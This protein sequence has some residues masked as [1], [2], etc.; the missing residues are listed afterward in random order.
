[1][2]N[3]TYINN[4]TRNIS[5]TKASILQK[6]NDDEAA[7]LLPVIVYVFILMSVGIVGNLIVLYIYKFRFRRS[8]SRAF[9]LCLAILDLITCLFGMPF[10][11]ID[12]NFPFLFVWDVPCKV[13]YFLLSSTIHASTFI[14]VLI[15]IERYRKI[16]LPFEKQISDIGTKAICTGCI[17]VAFVLST[18]VLFL[19]G[20]T[21]FDTG[22]SNITGYECYISNDYS[23]SIFPLIYDIVTIILFVGSTC[24]LTV[25][26]TRIG[27]KVWRKGTFQG[28]KTKCKNGRQAS[29]H[30]KQS[31]ME[32]VIE[33]SFSNKKE[34]PSQLPVNNKN[35]FDEYSNILI[36]SP[37]L[38]KD[39]GK[40][41][42]TRMDIRRSS[43]RL[44]W[45]ESK[46][47]STRRSFRASFFSGKSISEESSSESFT[48]TLERKS[49]FV[50]E[51]IRMTKF[52][53]KQRRSL[54]ITGMLSL[55]TVVFVISFLPYLVISILNGLD[56]SFWENMTN[57][58]IL[59]YNF[60]LRTYFINNMAN[61][62]IYGFL[63]EKFRSEVRKMFKC[64]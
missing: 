50:R 48:S 14:L 28:N 36:N 42:E 5:E 46:R 60:L 25:L 17:I 13:L 15:S 44:K 59:I 32:K 10:H 19:Y 30:S 37:K 26:Y 4:V 22:V 16:C 2:S 24:T 39:L 31:Q 41:T 9:I 35:T 51:G 38:R 33:T 47:S 6:L 23:D 54:R 21:S 57:N 64:C 52:S 12:M 40:K 43:L 8:S 18:P 61:P 49:K 11:V 45:P 62:I 29:E 20:V 55:I 56:E 58:K 53:K 63:D 1:M 7:L 3:L 34:Q 27:I